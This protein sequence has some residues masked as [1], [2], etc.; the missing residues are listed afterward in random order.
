MGPS[1]IINQVNGL[2]SAEMTKAEID[3]IVGKFVNGAANCKKAGIDGVE[4]HAAHGYLLGSFISPYTNKRTDDYGGNAENCCRIVTDIIRGIRAACG[5]YPVCVRI[6]G[7]DFVEGGITLDY[8][9]QVARIFGVCWRRR[10]QCQL[11]GL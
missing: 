9:V 2:V 10:H 1:A 5:N 8:A 4:L 6:N 11:C 7:S 3:E